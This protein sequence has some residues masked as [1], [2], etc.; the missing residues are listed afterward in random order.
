MNLIVKLSWIYDG[1]LDPFILKKVK[2]YHIKYNME[3]FY[4]IIS[5]N[6]FAKSNSANKRTQSMLLIFV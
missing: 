2:E 6:T 1:F 4:F 3:I 5:N